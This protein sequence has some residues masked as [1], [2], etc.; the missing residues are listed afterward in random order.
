MLLAQAPV[1]APL[2]FE[3]IVLDEHAVLLDVRVV[4]EGEAALAD[5]CWMDTPSC[6]A[7]AQGRRECEVER[8]ELKKATVLPHWVWVAAFA[9]GGVLVGTG[10]GWYLGTHQTP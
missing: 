10:L 7:V 4:H 8:E 1:D 3:P 6:I 5:G 2:N 9:A